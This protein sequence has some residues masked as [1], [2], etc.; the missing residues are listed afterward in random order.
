MKDFQRG[1]WRNVYSLGDD[2]RLLF[3]H[4]KR[5]VTAIRDNDADAARKAMTEHL[6]FAE[7]RC[8]DYISFNFS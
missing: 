4:H 6:D 8:A 2:T 3:D 7:K 5:I 1:V